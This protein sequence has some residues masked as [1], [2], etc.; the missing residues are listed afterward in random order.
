MPPITLAT[1]DARKAKGRRFAMITAYDAG[2]AALMG[3]AGVATV[4]VGDSLGMVVQGRTATVAVT[5]DDM[6]YHTEC[7]AR[8]IAAGEGP[9]PLIVADLP[10]GTYFSPDEAARSAARLVA[11]GANVVKLEGGAWL[12]DTVAFLSARG[13]PVCAHLGLTPQTVDMLGGYKVQGKSEEGARRLREEAALLD[14]A[15]ARLLLL[16]CVP[17]AVGQA[18]TQAANVPV[19]GIGAGPATDGQVLVLHDMLGV[20]RGRTARFVKDYMAGVG[21]VEGAFRA[22]AQEVESGAYPAAEHC[23]G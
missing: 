19:I 17:N 13:L 3:P 4:L 6:V 18:V 10:L 21:S 2:F 16:E 5:L 12:A 7:V 9:A 14:Q 8:G 15:G 22:F 20:S 23:Y 1:L 11:A